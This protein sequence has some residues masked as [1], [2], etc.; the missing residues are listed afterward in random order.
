METM[1]FTDAYAI[2]TGCPTCK[3]P[4]RI[5]TILPEFQKTYEKVGNQIFTLLQMIDA[6][7]VACYHNAIRRALIANCLQVNQQHQALGQPPEYDESEIKRYESEIINVE[8]QQNEITAALTEISKYTQTKIPKLTAL[9]REY[10]AVK[11][12]N[13]YKRCFPNKEG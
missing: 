4:C 9:A 12:Q 13:A 5:P 11:Q 7:I 1:F 3:N 10:I 6:Y 2:P 8:S